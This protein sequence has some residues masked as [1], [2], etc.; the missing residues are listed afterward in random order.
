MV[1]ERK[2]RKREYEIRLKYVGKGKE[3]QYVETDLGFGMNPP[4]PIQAYS[5]SD[6]RKQM[7]KCLPKTV[8]ILGIKPM[9]IT[10]KRR[11]HPKRNK[12]RRVEMVKEKA[13]DRN[14]K[15]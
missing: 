5:V 2:R 1:K 9:P 13:K 6:A 12:R 3:P 11:K 10:K 7:E 4:H 14:V 15:K 8:R